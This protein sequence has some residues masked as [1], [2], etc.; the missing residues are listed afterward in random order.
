[1]KNSKQL[2]SILLSGTILLASCS[3]MT[4]IQSYPSDAKV[5]IDGQAVGK[6]PYIYSDTKIVGSTTGIKIMKDGYKPLNTYICRNEKGD[7]GAIVGG[8]FFWVPFLWTMKYQPEHN[9]ELV[10]ESD[11][12]LPIVPGQQ[13]QQYNTSGVQS[14]TERLRDLK[15]LLDEKVLTQEE[16]TKEKKKVLNEVEK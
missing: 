15:L 2:T 1:M 12:I 5:Y 13:Y 6:T 10:A 14:K 9:Y 4:M 16:Y 3:S 11:Q 8:L 7:V